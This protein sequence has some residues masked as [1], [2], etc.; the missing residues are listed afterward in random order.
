MS[1]LLQCR[2]CFL[3][4]DLK[5]IF[6]VGK[7]CGQETTLATLLGEL[8]GYQVDENESMPHYLCTK[9]MISLIK[10]HRFQ[11]RCLDAYKHFETVDR[12][13]DEDAQK[14]DDYEIVTECEELP[15]KVKESEQVEL[16]EVIEEADL[17]EELKPLKAKSFECEFCGKVLKKF[18]SYKYHLQIHSEH[19]SFRCE[20]CNES[21]KT[22]NAFDGHMAIHE[23]KHTCDICHK[24]YRQA[25]SLRSHMLTH[26]GVKVKAFKHTATRPLIPH[27]IISALDLRHLRQRNDPKKWLQKAHAHTYGH[28]ATHLPIL[29]KIIQI[30]LESVRSPAHTHRREEFRMQRL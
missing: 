8:L 29:P 4:D 20:H 30:F 9:C 6:K 13:K 7:I 14:V 28:Q 27:F 23:E 12:T 3:T 18:S 2:I 21:F 1:N 19:T 16:V 26:T 11:Q 5:S 22:K 17:V 15:E 25:A 10:A 24:M